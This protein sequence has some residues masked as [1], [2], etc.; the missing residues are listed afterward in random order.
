MPHSR[1]FC[2]LHLT[3]E[4]VWRGRSPENVIDEI[5]HIV[6]TYS[7]EQIDFHDDNIAFDKDRIVG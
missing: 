6:N 2:T 5:E 3:R 7:I 4:S 1:I